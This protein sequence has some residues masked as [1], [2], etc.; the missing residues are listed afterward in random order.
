MKTLYAFLITPMRATITPHLT[1]LDLVILIT[2]ARHLVTRE[3]L[4]LQNPGVP[5]YDGVSLG[6]A[7]TSGTTHLTGTASWPQRPDSSET[8]R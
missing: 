4:K 2:S 8:K 6:K 5:G 7:E 3:D 1:R